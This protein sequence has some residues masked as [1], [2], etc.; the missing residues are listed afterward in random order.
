MQQESAFSIVDEL[1]S[2]SEAVYYR[3]RRQSDDTPVVLKVLGSHQDD[4]SAHERL[5]HELRIGRLIGGLGNAM[6]LGLTQLGDRPALVFEPFSGQPLNSLAATELSL[7]QRLHIAS[8]AAAALARVHRAGVVH[9]DINPANIFIELSERG[10]TVTLTSFGI[11]QTIAGAEARTPQRSTIEG[12]LAFISPEQTGR[13]SRSIDHRSDLYSL[14]ITLYQLF[15]GGLP[16]SATNPFEWLYCHIAQRPRSPA[17]LAPELP[18]PLTEIILR[19]IEKRPDS[20]YQTTSG[21]LFDLDRC[22]EL[23]LQH[24]AVPDFP[25]GSR[26]LS[27]KLVV[28]KTLY[29]R[30]GELD[31]LREAFDRVRSGA[32]S[33]LQLLRGPA[34][35]G[36]S[37]I[38]EALQPHLAGPQGFF[39][40][41]KFD[42][43]KRDSP[44]FAFTQ[45]FAE[46]ANHLLVESEESLQRWR[47]E[48][49][50]A[51]RDN[52][53]VLLDLCPQLEPILGKQAPLSTVSPA[54]EELRFANAIIGFLKVFLQPE[55]FVVLFVDDL[56]WADANSLRLMSQLLGQKEH[57][58]LLVVGAYRD[59]EVSSSHPLHQ[60]IG[61]LRA[62][63]MRLSEIAVAPLHQA[64]LALLLAEALHQ[65]ASE[66][67]EL[68]RLIHQKSGGNPFFAI[69]LLRNLSEASTLHF[70]AESFRWRWVLSEVDAAAVTDNVVDLVVVSLERLDP[71]ARTL[72]EIA[73]CLG[74][75]S[76]ARLLALASGQSEEE[77]AT[78]IEP[79]FV[80]GLLLRR[81][82]RYQFLHDRVHQ[83][84]YGLMDAP[85]KAERHLAIARRLLEALDERELE[86]HVFDL[87]HHFAQ[88][89][90]LLD[91]EAE[92][93]Q[94]AEL[95]LFAGRKAKK[96]AAYLSAASIFELARSFLPANIWQTGYGLAWGLYFDA[97][98]CE[99][100]VGQLEQAQRL[101]ATLSDEAKGIADRLDTAR[102]QLDV[103]L[104]RGEF[105]AGVDTA[106]EGLRHVGIE[107]SAHPSDDDVQR[108]FAR[109]MKLIGKRQ[110]EELIDLPRMSNEEKQAAMRLLGV[111][112]GPAFFTDQNL[113]HLH[114]CH[115]LALSLEFGND[116]ASCHAYGWFGYLLVV[117]F[118]RFDDGYRFARLGY[119][120]AQSRGFAAYMPKS[121]FLVEITG[122][123][124]RP[125]PEILE[126]I[127]LGL[128]GAQE[129]GDTTL[130]CFCCNHIVADILQ[131]GVA[132]EQ[133]KGEAEQLLRFVETANFQDIYDLILGM[134]RFVANLRGETDTFSTFS[135]PGFDQDAF[136][137]TLTA[138]RMPTMVCWYYVTK[139][140]A[141]FYSGDHDQALAAGE[142]AR[143]LLWSSYAH[144]QYFE[145]HAYHALNL[146]ALWEDAP[147]TTRA[148]YVATIQD[149]AQLLHR[150]AV[151]FPPTFEWADALVSAELAR[152][153]NAPQQAIR[154]YE[155][156]IRAARRASFTQVEGLA[157]ERAAAF[158][159]GMG[160]ELPTLVHLRAARAAYLRWGATAKVSALEASYPELVEPRS[161]TKAQSATVTSQQ[162][163]TR[164][165][166]RASQ[167]LSSELS[168]SGLLEKM[169]H[170]VVEH[171][172]ARSAKVILADSQARF[173]LGA[174][175]ALVDGTLEVSV[176]QERTLTP[177]DAPLSLIQYA[178]R[179]MSTLIVGDVERS[180][181]FAQD[182]YFLARGVRSAIC[183][184]VVRQG[185]VIAAL[186]LDND[187]TTE[188]FTTQATHVLELLGS[189]L[190]ISLENAQLYASLE[191]E[192]RVRR[193]AEAEARAHRVQLKTVLDTIVHG[194]LAV[195]LAGT[196]TTVNPA[197]A[198]LLG[199]PKEALLGQD[200][201]LIAEQSGLRLPDGL[202]IPTDR[203]P[204]MRALRGEVV[205][206]TELSLV[207]PGSPPIALRVAAAPLRGRDGRIQ[208]AVSVLDDV[209]QLAAASKALHESEE[210][211]RTLS[212]HVPVGI[213]EADAERKCLFVN[214]RWSEMTGLSPKQAHGDGWR[215]A[216]SSPDC[217]ALEEAWDTTTIEGREVSLELSLRSAE[218]P[219]SVLGIATAV[220]GDDG[221]V[222][223]YLGIFTDIT[224][225]KRLQAEVVQLQKM[226][227]IGR[228]A[229]GVAH[230]FNNLLSVILGYA[231]IIRNQWQ[232]QAVLER[233]L[234]QIERA[235]EKAAELTRQLL[236]FSRRK[237]L[238]AEMLELD[239]DVI[240]FSEMVGRVIGEEIELLLDLGAPAAII[241]ADAGQLQQVLMNLAINAR[242]AMPQGGDLVLRTR[243]FELDAGSERRYPGLAPGAYAQLIV[244]DSG[245]GMDQATKA[246]IFEPFF[247]TK[248]V[249]QGTGLGLSTVFGIVQ[250]SGG[251]INVRSEAGQG[252]S[253]ELLF[254][255]VSEPR[256][257]VVVSH[258]PAAPRKA[259]ETILVVEDEEALRDFYC[260][261]L[262]EAGYK[263]LC[264]PNGATALRVSDDYT[265]PIQ[266]LMTDVVMPEMGGPELAQQLAIRREE[267]RVIFMSGYDTGRVRGVPEGVPLLAKPFSE[268]TLLAAIAQVLDGTTADEGQRSSI[269]SSDSSAEAPHGD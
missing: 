19:L 17:E 44:Y 129:V 120:L 225:R 108:E 39:L 104:A 212:M 114:A 150:W 79:A 88:G 55:R 227:A 194:V 7:A 81:D 180:T 72:V 232:V 12:N 198:E 237:K 241:R 148:Q 103:Q 217:Q 172:G 269:G 62:T 70:D 178:A 122:Y 262:L 111:L 230:D 77:L 159:R 83:A 179:T 45:A 185:E 6:P 82:E 58:R 189:Q 28:P 109:V 74:N 4:E 221:E 255:L 265:G 188:A 216:L 164:A 145:W 187:L 20:R 71:Q 26:D 51:V 257:S 158:Y 226:E 177:D 228:L 117:V 68:A 256:P 222:R 64:E 38:V 208:G 102:L 69:Q 253:F 116:E 30:E 133:V 152:I 3:A 27:E 75:A 91:T 56:Q 65:R 153:A 130:A 95:G 134:L 191:T 132:L 200:R 16:F 52:G 96:S 251:H 59:N 63:T 239:A 101:I 252:T 183:L 9:R 98:S 263:V 242:D 67:S 107:M 35:V 248:G 143:P 84:A 49:R 57:P 266:L 168:L 60:L 112:H 231:S 245:S 259:T 204:M 155:R 54:E 86:E 33:E 100:T 160:T 181:P 267:A 169:L 157:H 214:P 235:S 119:D 97:A 123:W 196:I 144:P 80:Q 215:R 73:A 199:L 118:E 8:A 176:A 258:A 233:S 163:D 94:V 36:K 210:R 174:E 61:Q 78:A 249:G 244:E 146:A 209:S 192:N 131:Q 31:A 34:G 121:A 250:Q 234:D 218:A 165:V 162:F 13:L 15:T 110:V 229:G 154:D 85:S 11:A 22:A 207:R 203:L 190:A 48:I 1:S 261:L 99:R 243:R 201:A 18:Q 182:P 32:G 47:R 195:D 219:L 184:P 173:S 2:N 254:P 240:T 147:S 136:E 223:G 40:G 193:L 37:A 66:V 41:A 5:R 166:L 25:L 46:L 128:R 247:T 126:W 124:S 149:H 167:S 139:L 90:T 151:H 138:D 236:V 115:M 105:S 238:K 42:Q 213:F 53:Q 268:V 197:A 186:Y 170:I 142:R 10:P 220:H 43:F 175:A 205:R 202:P 246:R 264:A 141:R 135:G 50:A 14:G 224:D 156:A 125:I 24:G 106:L 113:V 29:G 87:F 161:D 76:P 92:R 260:Q 171:A 21:L 127:R 23:W 140:I 93:L 211:F 137:A 206:D 89:A